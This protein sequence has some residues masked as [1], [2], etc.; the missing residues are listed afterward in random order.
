MC[1][2]CFI[3]ECLTAKL[4]LLLEMCDNNEIFLQKL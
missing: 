2:R 1:A 3:V 4:L